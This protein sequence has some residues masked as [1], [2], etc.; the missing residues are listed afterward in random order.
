[1]RNPINNF[2]YSLKKK[3]SRVYYLR[4]RYIYIYIY[5]KE[6]IVGCSNKYVCLI[7]INRVKLEAS[8]VCWKIIFSRMYFG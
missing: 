6:I 7:F 5:I 3:L 2:N 8:K 1:M 4:D